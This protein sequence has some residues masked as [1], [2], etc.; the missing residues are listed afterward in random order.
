V[1]IT[2]GPV[3]P[4]RQLYA[5]L[6]GQIEDGTLP[7]GGRLPSIADLSQQYGLAMTTVR[8]AVDQLKRDTLVVASPMGT[9][10]AEPGT[11][12]D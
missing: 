7:P 5:L 3:P 1:D 6:R 11:S 2:P 12:G 4:W 9:F 8:K 10:V